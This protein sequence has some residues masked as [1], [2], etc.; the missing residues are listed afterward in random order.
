MKKN[1]A[2]FATLLLFCSNSFG[3]K[4]VTTFYDLNQT[5]KHEV[6]Y[7]ND[8]GV[9]NGTYTEYS[10]YGGI[11]SQGKYQDDK[12]VGKWTYRDEKGVL[13]S[14]TNY[15][16]D[17]L[18]NG[19]SITYNNGHKYQEGYY[20]HGLTQTGHWKTWFTTDDGANAYVQLHLDEYFKKGMDDSTFTEYFLNG[21]IKI[22]GKYK[23][24]EKIGVWDDFSIEGMD[25]KKKYTDG[26]LDST[27]TVAASTSNSEKSPSVGTTITKPDVSQKAQQDK[28]DGGTAV[29]KSDKA[30][31]Y[32]AADA[33][34]IRKAFNVKG[35]ILK[36]T[37]V[38]GD[39]IYV[40]YTNTKGT[41][42]QGW[43][44]KSDLTI[45]Q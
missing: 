36:Y 27:W 44:L 41:V 18:P 21:K 12:K 33:S 45:K 14:E 29:V 17:G 26:K 31:Y 2:S 30:Y 28:P 23:D 6:Y 25:S 40:S 20:Q 4:V 9:K 43:M 15:D 5:E 34:T 32:K 35:D 39:F 13:A 7:T 24:G 16:N 3:Q 22:Y 8:Y 19:L 11:L 42:T 37:Q 38:S 1:I 10:L